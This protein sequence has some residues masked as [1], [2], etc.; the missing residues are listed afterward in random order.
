MIVNR[1]GK[2]LKEVASGYWMV[3]PALLAVLAIVAYPLAFA[4]YYGFMRVL[5][6]LAGEFVGL[7]N[8]SRMIEDPHFTEA[9]WTTLSTTVRGRFPTRR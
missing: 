9:L 7:E 3:L 4:T 1:V 5:P 2:A 8:Y 6:N